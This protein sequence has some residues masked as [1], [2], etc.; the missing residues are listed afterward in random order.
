MPEQKKPTPEEIAAEAQRSHG[1]ILHEVYSYL[2][3]NK[4]W[5]LTPIILILL[6][7]GVAVVVSGGALAP[8]I[9]TLF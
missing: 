6:V 2:R 5:W 1:G 4:K 3:Y 9:Y 8:L 7:V